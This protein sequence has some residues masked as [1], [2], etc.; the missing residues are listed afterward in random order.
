MYNY[1]TKSEVNRKTKEQI[2]KGWFRWFTFITL[3]SS[4][5][6]I[7]SIAHLTQKM[8][9]LKKKEAIYYICEQVLFV[10]ILT[11]IPPW[12]S[13]S[14]N[15]ITVP[16]VTQEL[17]QMMLLFWSVAC[18]VTPHGLHTAD[19]CMPFSN[20]FSPLISW[21][22]VCLHTLCSPSPFYALSHVYYNLA[23]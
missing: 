6:R 8:I 18:S 11:A 20:L 3:L 23:S 1:Y 2:Q 7:L 12:L 14:C 13:D 19:R 4:I 5:A 21:P 10:Y 16:L 22:L 17:E 15:F 9:T